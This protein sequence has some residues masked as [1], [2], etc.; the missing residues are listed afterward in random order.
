M[1]GF[2]LY[3]KVCSRSTVCLNRIMRSKNPEHIELQENVRAGN[4]SKATLDTLNSRHNAPLD[5]NNSSRDSNKDPEADYCPNVVIKNETWQ[6]L[7]EVHM[8]SISDGLNARDDDRPIALMAEVSASSP[9]R[10]KKK[11]K[12]DVSDRER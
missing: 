1:A 5:L 6:T 9:A 4:W 11:T 2:R 12:K 8:E 7:F 3:R 10:K